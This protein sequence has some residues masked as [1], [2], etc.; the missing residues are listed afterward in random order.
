MQAGADAE[1]ASR[2]HHASCDG[3]QWIMSGVGGL[4]CAIFEGRPFLELPLPAFFKNGRC[5]AKVYDPAEK[6]AIQEAIRRGK[7]IGAEVPR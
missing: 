5:S 3:C 2:H 1:I 7:P 4:R 6:R